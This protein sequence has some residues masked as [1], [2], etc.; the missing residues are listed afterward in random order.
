M[1][2]LRHKEPA[3]GLLLVLY[4]IRIGGF[5]GL[6]GSFIIIIELILK[7]LGADPPHGVDQSGQNI[8]YCQLVSISSSYSTL[9]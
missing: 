4:G 5:Q 9:E 8:K 3:K 2:L 7:F 6:K 1:V